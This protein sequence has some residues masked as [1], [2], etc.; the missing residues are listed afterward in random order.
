VEQLRRV[1]DGGA[2]AALKNR[3]KNLRPRKEARSLRMEAVMISCA[4][5]NVTRRQTLANLARTDW[6]DALLK[7]QLDDG[8]G[9]D[10]EQRQTRCAY[11]ALKRSLER[12]AD[13][14]LF[15]EDDLDFNRHIHHN[16]R[17]WMPVKT[18]SVALASLYNPGIRERA[19]DTRQNA[20]IVEAG[21]IFG[22]QA[23]LLSRDAVAH[24]VRNWN[25]VEGKQDMRISRLAG[26]LGS[27]ILYHAPSLVQHIGTASVWGG[28]FH[29]AMDFDKDW[30]T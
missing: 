26:R 30:K 7:V 11:V 1:W 14:I 3:L 16:L 19:C 25:W 22:S 23:F 27:P 21:S 15:L 10:Y 20:R 4:E 12:K 17:H 18:R 8:A 13:Y 5:R 29:Q 6:A 24:V 9:T 28:F 2:T